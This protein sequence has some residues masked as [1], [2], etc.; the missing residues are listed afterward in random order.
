LLSD[1]P[2]I[3][4]A[5][6]NVS[7]EDLLQPKKYQI[8]DLGIV[9]MLLGAISSVF[10]FLFFWL[11]VRYGPDVLRTNWFIGSVLTELIL[12]FSLRT[13]FFS[14]KAK[15]PSFSL[16]S[17]AVGAALITIIL[18]FTDF[19]QRVFSF[20]PPSP[21]QLGIILFIVLLYF[22]T[23]ESAKLLYYR[24]ANSHQKNYL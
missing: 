16:F 17:L 8:K 7:P 9:S 1:F 5:T 12:I 18:A 13:R 3:A 22:A 24:I 6:D 21:R 2:M 11:F 19:G 23:T 20:L 4:I 15:R 14:F 10:D